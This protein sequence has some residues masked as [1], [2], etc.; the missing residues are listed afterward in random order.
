MTRDIN[1]GKQTI[2]GSPTVAGRDVVNIYKGSSERPVPSNRALIRIYRGSHAFY[3]H[4]RIG[5]DLDGKQVASL[6]QNTSIE[7][8]VKPGHHEVVGTWRPTVQSQP[9]IL[10]LKSGDRIGILA[11]F[12]YRVVYDR[13]VLAEVAYD[14]ISHSR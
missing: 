10:D 5:I 13:I 3:P 7:L 4:M 12:V 6:R 14:S 2:H 9:L 1:F 8:T 11:S